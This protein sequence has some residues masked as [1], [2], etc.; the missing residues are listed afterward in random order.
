MRQLLFGAGL[1]YVT[2][3][4]NRLLTRLIQVHPLEIRWDSGEEFR[5]RTTVYHEFLDRR[6]QV[7][8]DYGIAPGAY[9]FSDYRLS[10]DTA[11]RRKAWFRT[12]LRWGGFFNGRRRDLEASVGWKPAVPLF[13]GAG[14]Q[15]NRIFLPEGE[16]AANVSRVNANLL[17]S[18]RVTLYN[19]LQY[20]NLSRRLGWQSRFYWILRPGDEIILVWNS[21]VREP[22][23]RFE[24]TESTLRLKLNYVH[25]F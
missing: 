20:D 6:F 24:L 11:Q 19:F 8:P 5:V 23:D 14:Y 1:D 4:D 12:S 21:S 22:L 16:F 10:F 25:R 13:L 3:L 17:L 18:P 7:H 2:D 9:D 15:R